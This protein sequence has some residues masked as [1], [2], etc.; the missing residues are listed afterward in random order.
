[1]NAQINNLHN[2][3]EK[4]NECFLT[5]TDALVASGWLEQDPQ[6]TKSLQSA[7]EHFITV[8]QASQVLKEDNSNASDD[9]D[10]VSLAAELSVPKDNQHTV[11]L[12]VNESIL[13][14]SG[15][16]VDSS[17]T[18]IQEL[19]VTF[20]KSHSTTAP[21]IKE[22]VVQSLRNTVPNIPNGPTSFQT[23]PYDIDTF[24]YV[25]QLPR[26]T[27]VFKLTFA[28]KL[29]IE[30]IRA[31]LRLVCTAEERSQLFYQVFN[32]VLDFPTRES[33]RALLSRILNENLNNSLQPPPESDLDKL[34]SEGESCVWLNASDV[35]SHFRSIGMDFDSSLDIVDVEINPQDLPNILHDTQGLPATRSVTLF[36]NGFAE[37]QQQQQPSYDAALLSSTAYQHFTGAAQHANDFGFCTID[38]TYSAQ[39]YENLILSVD[40]A[41]LIHGEYLFFRPGL[42][43]PWLIR[44]RRDYTRD[45]LLLQESEIRQKQFEFCTRE[46]RSSDALIDLESIELRGSARYISLD[47]K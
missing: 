22:T 11:P 34:W 16:G 23:R 3:I 20:N 31:G 46:S 36:G 8:V 29:H 39:C 7:I 30:A 12:P 40:V 1:L 15:P 47:V 2:T 24:N 6:V 44:M 28:Q 9:S 26:S 41:R 33:Y 5:F 4:L 13:T 27:N 32:R 37:S 17:T 14:T 42:D 25:P 21:K 45:T 18:M 19:Y 10:S 43:K 38:P 35:A